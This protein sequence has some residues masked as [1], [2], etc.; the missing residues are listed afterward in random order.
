MEYGVIIHTFVRRHESRVRLEMYD[1]N[2]DG[3]YIRQSR[4]ICLTRVVVGTSMVVVLGGEL[5]EGV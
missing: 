3:V 4:N 5:F 2:G 1:E